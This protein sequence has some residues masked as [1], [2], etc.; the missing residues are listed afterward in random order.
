MMR[1]A[2]NLLYEYEEDI[3]H[4]LRD[5]DLAFQ[6]WTKLVPRDLWSHF[7]SSPMYDWVRYNLAT[8][9]KDA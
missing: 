7:F 2:R 9:R 4:V 6:V 8:T 3:L 1:Y 5:C